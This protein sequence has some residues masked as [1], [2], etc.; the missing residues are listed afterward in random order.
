ML[1]IITAVKG[2]HPTSKVAVLSNIF[3]ILNLRNNCLLTFSI[4]LS[5]FCSIKLRTVILQRGLA[6]RSVA[7][8]KECFKLLRDE[9]LTKCCNG[10]PLEL[11][12]FL[13]VETYESVGET[14][15]QTLLKA[16][17]VKLQ[18]GASIQQYISSGDAEDGELSFL[19]FELFSM[20]HYKVF[21][22]SL[23]DELMNI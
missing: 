10:D 17:L 22:E 13:D 4:R 12:K 5:A 9:W 20:F 1:F 6:D 15:M 7:V 21:L 23:F 19:K 18:N 8:S 14:V 2:G 11:L 16:D 3:I